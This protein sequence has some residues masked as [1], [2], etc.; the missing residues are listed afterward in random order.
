MKKN[1]LYVFLKSHFCILLTFNFEC[2]HMFATKYYLIICHSG[3]GG[4]GVGGGDY[5][6][7]HLT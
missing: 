3:G 4:G 1:I 7:L 5:I 2:K 6:A